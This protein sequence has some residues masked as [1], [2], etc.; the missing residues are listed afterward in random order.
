M[1]SGEKSNLPI[2]C[3]LCACRV[4][5][6]RLF[7]TCPVC[8]QEVRERFGETYWRRLFQLPGVE[9]CPVHEVF[10]EDSDVGLQPLFNRHRFFAAERAKLGLSARPIDSQN[11]EHSILLQLARATAWLLE[12][13]QWNP[14]PDRIRTRYI[15]LLRRRD[16]VTLN[17]SVRMDLLK[18]EVEK[19]F[20]SALLQRLQTPISNDDKA[21][22]LGRLLRNQRTTVA[23]LRHLLLMNFLGANAEQIFDPLSPYFT[24]PKPEPWPCLNP[25]CDSFHKHV[26]E[27]QREAYQKKA[28]RI[29]RLFSCP[30]CSYTYA[31]Y[32]W[33]QPV[34]KP[35]YIHEFGDL[36]LS[37]LKEMWLDR[38]VS[39]RAMAQKLDV[40]SKTVKRYAMELGLGFPRRAIRTAT[41]NDLYQKR[42][43]SSRH[44]LQ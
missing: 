35:A 14:R 32:N 44:S 5:L 37:R 29:V 42:P 33:D 4:R 36:W 12:Q 22:W 26:I 43:R 19:H 24:T 1:A 18:R 15:E 2:R 20:G 41:A 40:D 27:Q 23:P 7:R 34:T 10:L 13:S 38:H 28:K 31:V 6:P 8:D 25:V 30:T 39:V 17:G 21:G 16:L 11:R 3:G 9:V